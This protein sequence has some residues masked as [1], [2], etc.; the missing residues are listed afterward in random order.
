[1]NEL[2]GKIEAHLRTTPL[3]SNLTSLFC[4]TLRW[5]APRGMTPLP[6]PGGPPLGH[7]LTAVPVAQLS[8]LPVFHVDWPEDR[9]PTVTARRAVLRALAPVHAKHLLCYVTRDGRQAAFVWARERPDGKI[10]LRTLPHEV[11]SP[12]RTTIDRLGELA[13]RLDELGPT[14]QPPI[15]AVIDK[16]DA[17]FSVERVTKLFYQEI[18]NWYFWA[19]DCEEVVFPKDVETPEDRALFLIRLLTRLIFC[20]FLRK[21]RNPRTGGGLLPDELFEEQY[22][23][24]LLKDAS[25]EACT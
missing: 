7:P 15:N 22:I 21:K 17:A 20:W 6:L 2:P 16:L 3:A 19:R 12:A 18:A 4:D 5:G 1:M 8:G 10:E 25:P 24:G 14:G 13:F 9:P 11:G 23:R